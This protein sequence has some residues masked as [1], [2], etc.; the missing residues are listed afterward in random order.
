[1]IPYESAT[2]GDKALNDLQRMLEKFGCARFGIMHDNEKGLTNVQF[3]WRDRNVSL[4][5]SWTGYACILEKN[6]PHRQSSRGRRVS[7]EE[8]GR[9]LMAQA[10][11]SVCSVLRDWIKGQVTAVECGIMSFETAFMPHILLSN[12]Q[13][14]IDVVKSKNLLE[15]PK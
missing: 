6:H 7:Y 10:K 14:V 3:T 11:I 13:R 12:G 15:A 1:M 4:E 9:R 8:Y 5:A 2:S